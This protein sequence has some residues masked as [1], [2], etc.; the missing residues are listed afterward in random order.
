MD[1][2]NKA[3]NNIAAS[4]LKVGNNSTSDIHFW[5]TK[6]ELTLLVL[7]FSQSGTT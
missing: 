4:Y 1:G 5:Y 2:F 3:C 7:Y 6:W